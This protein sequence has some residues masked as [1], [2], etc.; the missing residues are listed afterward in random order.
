M[1]DTA[2]ETST[3]STCDAPDNLSDDELTAE[4]SK[5]A[6]QLAA[7]HARMVELAAEADHRGLW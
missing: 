6:A 2:V 3:G 5:L 4:V 1:S 7:G